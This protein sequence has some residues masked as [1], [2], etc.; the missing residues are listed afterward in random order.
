[1]SKTTGFLYLLLLALILA[2]CGK[3]ARDEVDFGTFHQSVYTNKYF[4]FQLTVPADWSV[5]DREAQESLSKMGNAAIAGDDKKLKALIKATE[6]QTVQLFGVSRHKL[7]ALVNFNPSIMSVAE[8]I[9]HMPSI[10]RGKDYHFHVRKVLASSAMQ[11]SF[12][13]DAYSE[14]V[15]GVEF[16]VL[17]QEIHADGTVIKQKWFTI[18]KKGYA[19]SFAISYTTPEDEAMLRQVLATLKFP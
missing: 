4:G 7:E 11:V 6:P 19:L 12:P 5:H 18:I 1:M 3:K 10:K 8:L 17:D 9:R 2:G 13:K 15:A 14:T 16:D